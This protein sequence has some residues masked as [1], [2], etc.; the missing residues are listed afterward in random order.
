MEETKTSGRKQNGFLLA[1]H[2]PIAQGALESA[3]LIMGTQ[4]PH[5]VMALQLQAGFNLQL[6]EREMN[7]KVEQ[8][9]NH[10]KRVIIV[11]DLLGGTPNNIASKIFL[12]NAN[13]DLITG[14]NLGL[15]L[16]LLAQ[17]DTKIDIGATVKK[18]QGTIK[19]MADVVAQDTEVEEWL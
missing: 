4:S 16:E 5:R 12:T 8:L 18:A 11:T 10:N 14:M 1:S 19:N 7:A 6:F 9:L 17:S 15:I 2:G 13:V 3:Q